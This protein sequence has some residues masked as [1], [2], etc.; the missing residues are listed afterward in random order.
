MIDTSK[1]YADW[2]AEQ[3]KKVHARYADPITGEIEEENKIPAMHKLCVTGT[4]DAALLDASPWKT[5][6]RLFE[7]MTFARDD[8]EIDEERRFTF[9]L[10]HAC[11]PLIA[12]EFSR[13]THIKLKAGITK[14]FKE[15]V[16]SGAQIDYLTVDDVPMECKTASHADGWGNGCLFNSD[17]KVL[18]ADSKI[19][20]YYELQ[21][22][23][24]MALMECKEMW[25]SCFMTFER[26]IRIY[27]IKANENL[28]K[29]I[30]AAEDDFMF[31]HVIP[32]FPFEQE[33]KPLSLS[34]DK[35]ENSCFADEEFQTLLKRYKEL[36]EPYKTIP[37]AVRKEMNDITAKLKE[38]MGDAKYCV[39]TNGVELCHFT[40][41]QGKPFFDEKR[42]ADEQ[43]EMYSKYMTDGKFSTKFFIA[44]EKRA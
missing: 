11:E 7:E 34:P 44:K 12:R 8:E 18:R 43:P 23:K 10:G 13:I 25:L 22:Q 31:C 17:G 40:V 28:Q 32:N 16:W 2:A 6:Q 24:Q 15:R 39:N 29:R 35:K 30:A 9:D 3:L 37:V 38:K 21:C 27:L 26:G 5:K 14:I 4:M 20:F 33:T 41:S 42:F 1:V 36:K 19:P